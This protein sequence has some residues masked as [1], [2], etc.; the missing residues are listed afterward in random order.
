VISPWTANAWRRPS[1]V[2][3]QL[4][5]PTNNFFVILSSLS[6]SPKGTASN[7]RPLLFQPSPHLRHNSENK[8]AA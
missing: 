4:S 8:R 5:P 2:V 1:S 3:S 6:A 7:G